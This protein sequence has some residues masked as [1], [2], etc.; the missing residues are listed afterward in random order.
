VPKSKLINKP[1]NLGL[2]TEDNRQDTSREK[3][4][5]GMKKTPIPFIRLFESELYLS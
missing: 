5:S 4:M 3:T 2:P 1:T